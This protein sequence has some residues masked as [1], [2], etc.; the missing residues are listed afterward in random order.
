MSSLQNKRILLGVTGGIAAYKSPDVVRRLREQ[1]ADVRVVMTAGAMEFITP[2]SLQ[3]VSGNKVSTDLLDEDA[4]AA[5]GHIEFARWADAIVIAP[6]TADCLARLAQGR[7]DDLLTTLV[8]AAS[9]P[10]LIAPAMNQGMWADALTQKN[11]QSLESAGYAFVGPD[12]GSQACGDVG[13]GRMSEAADIVAATSELFN[14]GELAGVS[15]VITAGPTQEALDPVRYISNHSSGK[16]GFALAEAA[17]E[18]GAKVTL[19]AG[20]VSL[21]TPDRVERI[22]VVSALDMLATTEQAVS[23]DAVFIATAAVADFRPAEVAEQKMKKQ[24]DQN[25]MLVSLVKNPD[26]LATVARSDQRPAVVVGF[27]AES[28]SLAINAQNKLVNKNLDLII[29]N[30]IS[31]SDIG[32]GSDSNE[33]LV[34]SSHQ[35]I[36]P[37]SDWP[38]QS[39]TQLARDIIQLVAATYQHWLAQHKLSADSDHSLVSAP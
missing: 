35:E 3:A 39:K 34:L 5:M 36:K 32:F 1:G 19:I 25:E 21:P 6:A 8:R 16:M 37:A 2:L 11:R 15:V 12:S 18:A 31:R 33:V 13:A 7:A 23:P 29:A 10:I 30:D 27:A 9:C 22:D 20:P 14:S 4:E 28:E 17:A 38:Q 26:I 24:S